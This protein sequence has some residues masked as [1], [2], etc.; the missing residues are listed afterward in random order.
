MIEHKFGHVPSW[1]MPAFFRQSCRCL[2]AVAVMA[3]PPLQLLPTTRERRKKLASL[4]WLRYQADHDLPGTHRR[5]LSWRRS[6]G[7][8][9]APAFSA[10]SS[11][12][13][14]RSPGPLKERPAVDRRRG[15]APSTSRTSNPDIFGRRGHLPARS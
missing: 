13:Y 6:D 14:W 7:C 9:H 4:G 2:V 12:P 10:S 1:P 3:L 8:G 15:A 5:V 11:R